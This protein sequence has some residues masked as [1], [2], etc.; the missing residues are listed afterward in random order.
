MFEIRYGMPE[1]Y[2]SITTGDYEQALR[3]YDKIKRFAEEHNLTW[4]IA[5]WDKDWRLMKSVTT[6]AEQVEF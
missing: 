5:L 3:M 6:N 2:K 1:R 4:I